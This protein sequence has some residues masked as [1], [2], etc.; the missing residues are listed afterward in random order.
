LP[1]ALGVGQPNPGADIVY[2]GG[3]VQRPG[4]G[5]QPS[6]HP[7]L[8]RFTACPVVQ[9]AKTEVSPVLFDYIDTNVAAFLF[10][11]LL[12]PLLLTL[13][14]PSVFEIIFEYSN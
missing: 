2:L 7:A 5:I 11:M 3:S 4:A 14:T 10:Y 13:T 8:D 1:D 12:P 9:Q 6:S